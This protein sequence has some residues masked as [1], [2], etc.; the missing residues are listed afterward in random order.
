VIY[1]VLTNSSVPKLYLAGI[2]PGLL[3]A[4]LF[5][6]TIILACMYKPAW[7]GERIHASWSERLKSLVHLVPPMGIFLLV[8]GSIYAGVATPTEAAA[9]GVLGA[10]LLAAAY[11]RLTIAMVRE[12]LENTMRSSAMIMLIVVGA[13]FLNF[14]MSATGLTTALT[15]AITGLG[16][17][18]FAMLLLLIVFYLVLG[19]FMETLSMM[20]TT[21]PIVAPVMIALGFDPIWLGIIIIVLVEAALITPPVGLNLFV[22][23]SLRT[24]GSM[25]PVIIGSIPFVVAMML[26]LLLLA[27]FPAL[28]LWLPKLFAI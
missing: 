12:S 14:V 13:S 22:V 19:C 4:S 18:P 25:T 27:L 5:M 26:L 16:F 24:S 3:L 2:L 23:Q 17:S 9:L 28:A 15:N 6:L 1:G 8:V 21:I 7:G 20:I 10:M 11:R